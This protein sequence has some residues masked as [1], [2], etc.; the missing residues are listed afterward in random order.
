MSIRSQVVFWGALSFLGIALGLGAA[1]LATLVQR[2]F[3]SDFEIAGIPF[4]QYR[5]LWLLGPILFGFGLGWIALVFGRRLRCTQC[6]GELL[7]A[8]EFGASG[9][10]F[11]PL[12]HAARGRNVCMQCSATHK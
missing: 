10:R 4:F 6:G 12:I 5:A 8:D 2:G 7:P 3:L 9:L 1:V 11:R